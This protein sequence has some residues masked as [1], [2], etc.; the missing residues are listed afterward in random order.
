M[1]GKLRYLWSASC[2]Q[3]S[4]SSPGVPQLVEGILGQT[5]QKSCLTPTTEYTAK[6]TGHGGGGGGIARRP[7]RI[8]C[9]GPASGGKKR[10]RKSRPGRATPRGQPRRRKAME[11]GTRANRS[12]PEP[13]W[14]KSGETGRASLSRATNSRETKKANHIVGTGPRRKASLE[15][16]L[17]LTQKQPAGGKTH[18][19]RPKE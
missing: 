15:G 3:G 12:G 13:V 5:Q 1:I 17:P 2:S 14:S 18:Y 7:I 8:R 9:L 6:T 16:K 11:E 19:P 10:T 4:V